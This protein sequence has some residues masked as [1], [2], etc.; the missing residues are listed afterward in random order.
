MEFLA[1]VSRDQF[2]PL[3]G[4]IWSL[5]S[6]PV[7]PSSGVHLEPADG[8]SSS[9]FSGSSGACWQDQFFPLLGFV[10]SLLTGP[11]IPHQ[12]FVWSLLTGP[13]HPSS[14]DHLEPA[15][16]SS[17]SLFWGSSGACWQ[18]RFIPLLGFIWRLLTGP[19]L[20]SSGVRLEPADRSGSS[21]FWGPS[22]WGRTGGWSSIFSACP[23]PLQSILAGKLTLLGWVQYVIPILTIILIQNWFQFWL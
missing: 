4:F 5:L 21:L 15:D 14:G 7:H 1:A 17:S 12:R 23:S 2:I 8:I 22:E 19:V 10:W 18:D 11:V 3:L 13:V 16:R 9:L 6:G 20:H